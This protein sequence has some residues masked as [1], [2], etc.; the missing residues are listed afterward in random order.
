MFN[1]KQK[2]TGSTENDG[3]K[4]FGIM[5]PLKYL[6]NFWRTPKIP[7]TSCEINLTWSANCVT[8]NTVGPQATKFGIT[9]TK[10]TVAVV[11][12]SVD[13]N[14]KLLQQL[15]SRLKRTIKWNK[16]QTKQ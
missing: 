13:D 6:S 14:A 8:S 15:K 7:L 2:I 3:T 16:Y 9:N 4:N 1:F 5:V 10:L 12:L 11:T